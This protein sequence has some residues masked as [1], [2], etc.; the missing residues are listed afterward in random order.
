[1]GGIRFL[2][3]S[4]IFAAATTALA[5]K[6]D[7]LIG[8][9]EA[10]L[11][12]RLISLAPFQRFVGGNEGVLCRIATNTRQLRWILPYIDFVVRRNETKTVALP[13]RDLRT[14]DGSRV[15]SVRFNYSERDGYITV[16][17]G[18]ATFTLQFSKGSDKQIHFIRARENTKI[19]I[20]SGVSRG[21]VIRFDQFSHTS[22]RYTLGIGERFI[23]KNENGY[24]IQG[25][26][27]GIKDGGS[28]RCPR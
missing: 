19:A 4:K 12:Q 14:D 17:E 6:F 2:K 11:G 21:Q 16:G 13:S 15:Q 25:H 1:M 8:G 26:V 23:V 9:G 7:Q 20:A 28:S 27:I 3:K 10:K 22:T 24:F 5:E 18:D